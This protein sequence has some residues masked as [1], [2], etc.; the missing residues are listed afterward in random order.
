MEVR[1]VESGAKVRQSASQ[2]EAA[3]AAVRQAILGFDLAPGEQVTEAQL[4]D[5]F[6]FG[7]AAVR[8]ALIKLCHE[9]LVQVIPRHGYAI[10]PITFAYVRELFGVRLVVEP[11]A[12]RLAAERSDGALVAEL[13][14]LNEACIHQPDVDLSA[15]RRANKAFHAA[16]G[17]ACGNE[18]LAALCA[19]VLDEM[20]RVLYL[21]QLATVWERA[22]AS[23]EE[24][25][26]IVEA[27]RRRDS[28]LAERAAHDHV[29]PNQRGVID[30]LTA[31]PGLR[32]IN[33]MSV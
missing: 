10:S 23:F 22:D 17:R 28:P 31:S 33:L 2:G 5:R 24:H 3:Y 21:P 25:A 30:A 7:R 14:R 16:I 18:R 26:R 27:I 1:L 32:F 20:D 29:V 11:A 8:T 15:L 12:A 4:A 6:G 9:Q 13:E 19:T